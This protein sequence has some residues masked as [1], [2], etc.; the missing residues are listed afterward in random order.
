[1]SLG[2]GLWVGYPVPYP[3]AY[4]DPYSY[5]YPYAYPYPYPYAY[6]N[7]YPYQ[8]PSYGYPPPASYPTSYPASSYPPATIE[9]RPGAVA[10]G[11]ISLEITP[12]N[13]QVFV[14]DAYVGIVTTFG[15]ASAPLTLAPGRHRVEVRAAGYQT[16][17]FD[18][19]VTVGEVIPYRGEMQP[20]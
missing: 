13:A 3:Y 12:G 15:P 10:S 2:F 7:P 19:D 1:V 20:N 18:V 11:G 17:E 5:S 6:P 9:A 14:D 16:L 4:A 8:Y